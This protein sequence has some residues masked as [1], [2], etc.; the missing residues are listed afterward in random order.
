MSTV[1]VERHRLGSADVDLRP[2][3][4]DL[5]VPC[6]RRARVGL[7]IEAADEFHR[8][9]RALLGRESKDVGKKVTCSHRIVLAAPTRRL[10]T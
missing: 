5:G 10:M 4:L 9:P 6:V 3:A 2:T 8:K 7:A 1:L